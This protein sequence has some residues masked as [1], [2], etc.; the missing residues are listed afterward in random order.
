M[1]RMLTPSPRTATSNSIAVSTCGGSMKRCGRGERGGETRDRC[2]SRPCHALTAGS[3]TQGRACW[4]TRARVQA[5]THTRQAQHIHQHS[6]RAKTRTPS[7]THTPAY[8][9]RVRT[10]HPLTSIASTTTNTAMKMRK[11]PLMNPPMTCAR[12]YLQQSMPIRTVSG[13]QRRDNNNKKKTSLA[14]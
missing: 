1:P 9:C 11:R 4:M 12:P 10:T 8:Q 7:T 13:R 2:Q 6:S 5:R 14:G 3:S